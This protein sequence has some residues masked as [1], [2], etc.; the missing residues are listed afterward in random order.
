MASLPPFQLFSYAAFPTFVVGTEVMLAATPG[1]KGDGCLVQEGRRLPLVT[2]QSLDEMLLS[3]RSLNEAAIEAWETTTLKTRGE[4]IETVAE[5]RG[6]I[7]RL[8][9]FSFIFHR[10]LPRI[11]RL[12]GEPIPELP[13]H[14]S[15]IERL[16]KRLA[17]NPPRVNHLPD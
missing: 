12:N 4:S 7:K 2:V 14:P 15:T 17:D 6:K 13:A 1:S 16:T 5:L 11:L 3:Y 8:E 9:T 10:L